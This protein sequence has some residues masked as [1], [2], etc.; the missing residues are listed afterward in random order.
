MCWNTWLQVCLP[1]Q[2]TFSHTEATSKEAFLVFFLFSGNFSITSFPQFSALACHS[3]SLSRY[4][5]IVGLPTVSRSRTIKYIA[6]INII[7]QEDCQRKTKS[8][9]CFKRL[10]I[11]LETVIKGCVILLMFAREMVGPCS[12]LHWEALPPM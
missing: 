8:R 6:L 2:Q 5:V 12:G 7:T 10:A 9:I 11:P 4:G 1:E 3:R